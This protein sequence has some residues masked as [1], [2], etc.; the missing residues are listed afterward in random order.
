[1]AD[2]PAGPCLLALPPELRNEIYEYLV[3]DAPEELHIVKPKH[4]DRTSF[5]LTEVNRQLRAET[6]KMFYHDNELH[7][8]TQT[9]IH[10]T[11]S[12]AWINLA[13]PVTVAATGIFAIQETY[14][15]CKCGRPCELRIYAALDN[16]RAEKIGTGLKPCDQCRGRRSKGLLEALRGGVEDLVEALEVEG[17]VRVMSKEVLTR[18]LEVLM[19]TEEVATE[20]KG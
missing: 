18:M 9:S 17:G 4:F 6:L 13:D 3:L 20:T 11:K 5:N 15:S 1:M 19:S 16:I 14:P 8:S 7:M 12:Q 2:S 10:F